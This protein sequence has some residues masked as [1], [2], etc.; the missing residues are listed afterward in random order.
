MTN[1]YGTGD[2]I[3]FADGAWWF[4]DAIFPARLGPYPTEETALLAC[5][6]YIM[7]WEGHLSWDQAVDDPNGR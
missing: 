4:W 6:Q 7:A 1:P 2:P 5:R 3:E